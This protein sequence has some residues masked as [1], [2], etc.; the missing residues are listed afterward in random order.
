MEKKA[1]KAKAIELL[2]IAARSNSR[3][4]VFEAIDDALD[5]IN[6]TEEEFCEDYAEG[7]P[8]APDW[9]WGAAKLLKDLSEQS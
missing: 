2:K 5:L 1:V 7:S 4:K 9:S 6:M 8:K 3:A